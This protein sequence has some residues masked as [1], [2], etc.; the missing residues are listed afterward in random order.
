[1]KTTFAMIAL[2]CFSFVGLE[3]QEHFKVE[4]EDRSPDVQDLV[5]GY[6]NFPS[7]PIIAKDINGVEHNLMNYKE[8]EKNVIMWFMNLNC[9]KCLNQI[10]DLNMLQE[11]YGDE[12]QI[13]ALGDDEKIALSALAEYRPINFPMIPNCKTLADGPYGGDLGYPRIFII[14]EF[15]VVKWVFPQE[16]MKNSFETFKVLEALHVQLKNKTKSK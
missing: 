10:D 2:L 1:M 7:I 14:D 9:P 3:A 12:L 6:E 11:K 13:L 5:K 8:E 15:G 4:L 16:Q